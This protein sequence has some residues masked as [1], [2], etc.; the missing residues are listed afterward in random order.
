MT[1]KPYDDSIGALWV[2]T[3]SKGEYLTGTVNG[4]RVVCFKNT[5]KTSDKQPEW[6]VLRGQTRSEREAR[7]E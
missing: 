2:K 7:E 4:V 5:K 3:S 6:R 1:D